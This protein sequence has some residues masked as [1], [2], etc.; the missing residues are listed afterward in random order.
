VGV[1]EFLQG[2]SYPLLMTYLKAADKMAN[3]LQG[4]GKDA[5][6]N[7]QSEVAVERLAQIL[8]LSRTLRNKASLRS[9]LAGVSIEDKALQELNLW[10]T[11]G[12]LRPDLLRPLLDELNRHAAETPSALDCLQ[13]ECFRARGL[14]D[15][16][17]AWA[18]RTQVV[19]PRRIRETWVA[20]GVVL[21]LGMPWEHE[22]KLR[23]WRA[24]WAG[25]FRALRTPYWQLPADQGEPEAAPDSASGILHGWLPATEGPDSSLTRE[26]LERLLRGSWLTDARLFAQV[27]K[28]RSASTR[29][30][31]QVD[32]ARLAVALG[33]YQFREG[34]PA[35]RLENLVPKYLAKLPEDP[36]SGQPFR[37]RI[38]AGEVI[39][40]PQAPA[41]QERVTVQ[42]GQGVTWSTG[43]D[44][45]D[46]E[47][48]K[49]GGAVPEGDPLWSN[50]GLDLVT[51][52]PRWP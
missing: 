17:T 26:R 20:D 3:R 42:S 16:P 34:K 1:I 39:E 12:K 37:Y 22:R 47:G 50:G 45:V 4:L 19:V 27:V 48:R 5:L 9:Y 44:R 18:F 32:A 21:S 41:G 46:H 28:L 43:P 13:M 38:S 2:D 33:L 23:L 35:Q 14:L 7:G 15:T 10:L 31:W 29:T 52:T 51:L 24:V 49:H 8:A 30:R 25:L 11:Q 40:Q 36:Y 6:A